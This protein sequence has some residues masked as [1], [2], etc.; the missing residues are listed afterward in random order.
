MFNADG[1]KIYAAP[2]DQNVA[3]DM[4]AWDWNGDGYTDWLV[5]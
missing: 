4:V 2:L 3:H 5:K 1:S